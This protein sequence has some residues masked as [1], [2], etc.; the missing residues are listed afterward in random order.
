MII[1]WALRSFAKDDQCL[2]TKQKR[3]QNMLKNKQKD[4][5]LKIRESLLF[6]NE[7]R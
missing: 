6:S 3:I 2:I 5:M 7:S 4:L 1:L